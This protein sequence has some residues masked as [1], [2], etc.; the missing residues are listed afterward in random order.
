MR[1]GQL[2]GSWSHTGS[3]IVK[4]L[5]A[6]STIEILTSFE[7]VGPRQDDQQKLGGEEGVD[8]WVVLPAVAALTCSTRFDSTTDLVL[9]SESL[10]S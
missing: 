3:Q 5:N 8:D 1:F 10:L 9:Q 6:A 7:K 2:G 4:Y